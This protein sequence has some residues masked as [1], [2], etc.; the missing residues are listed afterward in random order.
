MYDLT[1][2]RGVALEVQQRKQSALQRAHAGQAGGCRVL[3]LALSA[4]VNDE[5][6]LNSTQL[7]QNAVDAQPW[8]ERISLDERF[9][10]IKAN[11]SRRAADYGMSSIEIN[12]RPDDG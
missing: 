5:G 10:W 9:Q 8:D 11:V 1:G 7:L 12:G 6:L 3:P 4:R 2:G